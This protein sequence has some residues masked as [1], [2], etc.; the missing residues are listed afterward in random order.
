[1][2]KAIS[3]LLMAAMLVVMACGCTT[4]NPGT[5]AQVSES[6]QESQPAAEA[7][8]STSSTAGNG[9]DIVIGVAS[10]DLTQEFYVHMIDGSNQAAEEDGVTVSWKSADSNLDKQIALIENF[11]QQ[12][13]DCIMIDPYDATGLI[14]V[15]EEAAA[16][17]IPVLSMGNFIDSDAVVSCLYNDY[18]DTK[19]I[20]EIDA[21][22]CGET[23]DVALLYGAAGNFVSDERQRGFEEAI[24]EFPN[25][26]CTSLAIGW[27]SATAL[28]VTQDLLAAK[29]NIKAIHCFSDG[30]TGAVYQAVE[31]A[32]M[33]DKIVIS[34]YD[35]N[36]DASQA[37]KDGK[38]ALTLLT[39]AKRVGYWCTKMAVKLA[40]GEELNQKNYLKSH[41]IM[42]DDLKSK[43]QEW[44]I[45]YDG[46]DIITPDQ[47][48]TMFDD[49]S[50]G[51]DK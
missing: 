49:L 6:A 13:V 40:N 1:M 11:I 22:L 36:T 16:A 10:L 3:F 18:Q 20:G 41:F 2:K 7:T 47:G 5:S 42:N 51:F 30:E 4:S 12:G 33:L 21:K 27:D 24:A 34:S 19:V 15:C 50:A 43:V 25:M 32:D 35:G 23:G 28:K 9:S 8:T 31:Q 39:G 44:G 14:P 48:I 37:V 29:P 26:T 17:G 46:M 38:Y 45:G